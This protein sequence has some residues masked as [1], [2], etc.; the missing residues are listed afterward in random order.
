MQLYMSDWS[1]GTKDW[2]SNKM[3]QT[4]GRVPPQSKSNST[5][6]AEEDEDKKV[7]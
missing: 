2:K 7:K 3:R 1:T 5:T 6:T 4:L